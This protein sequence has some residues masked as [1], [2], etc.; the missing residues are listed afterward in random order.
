MT[1]IPEKCTRCGAPISWEEGASVL[2]CEYCGY[3]NNVKDDFRSLFKNY[4]KLRDP[5][6]I[7]KNPI[8][9]F[10]LLPIIFLALLINSPTKKQE[11]LKAE[12]WP[13]NWDRLKQI[14]VKD[15]KSPIF[16][17]NIPKSWD[18]EY[19][20]LLTVR[21]K[22]DLNEAC[23]YTRSLKK[24]E[25]LYKL[26][27]AK[28]LYDFNIFVGYTPQFGGLIPLELYAD[29]RS[30]EARG[31]K[32][33]YRNLKNYNYYKQKTIK[34]LEEVSEFLKAN[35]NTYLDY[36]D[37]YY[38]TYD[39]IYKKDTEEIEKLSFNTYIKL[40][41][42]YFEVMRQA[43]NKDWKLTNRWSFTSGGIGDLRMFYEEKYKNSREYKNLSKGKKT[44]WE[45]DKFKDWLLKK[46]ILKKSDFNIIKNDLGIRKDF[47]YN[48]F[49]YIF[50]A[51]SICNI[52]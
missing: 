29:S 40:R 30:I 19:K 11:S 35:P 28:I 15:K 48:F 22:K 37:Y 3:K 23:E 39:S 7:I 16:G 31:F 9:L 6:K 1:N 21:F 51:E 43:G 38:K 5:K 10:F 47:K 41:A 12:Y 20:E 44:Y 4:L 17:K 36:F 14:K 42:S 49:N 26:Q 13:T 25:E 34:N 32:S 46:G 24:Q 33:K 18:K 45:E 52:E 50:K 27:L 2:K 8:S